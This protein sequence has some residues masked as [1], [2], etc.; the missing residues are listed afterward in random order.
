[1]IIPITSRMAQPH[2]WWWILLILSLLLSFCFSFRWFMCSPFMSP[3]EK[4]GFKCFRLSKIG[5][6]PLRMFPRMSPRYR[7]RR[8]HW[9]CYLTSLSRVVDSLRNSRGRCSSP[10]PSSQWSHSPQSLLSSLSSLSFIPFV[11]DDGHI[12]KG[13]KGCA[14]DTFFVVCANP[15]ILGAETHK[16]VF[17]QCIANH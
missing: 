2:W 16:K 11:V 15:L 6:R 10:Q 5:F 7:V 1:M 3:A 4:R 14:Q 12:I 13:I 17:A 8:H 9:R